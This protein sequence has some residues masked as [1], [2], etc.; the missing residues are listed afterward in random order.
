MRAPLV[1]LV[2]VLAVA[3]CGRLAESRLNPFNWFGNDEVTP[4]AATPAPL[5]ALANDPRPLVAEIA[6][7]EIDPLPDG[8]LVRATG[9]PPTQGYWDAALIPAG[10]GEAEGQPVDGVLTF[11]FVAAPPPAPARVST[12]RSRALT[13]AAFVSAQGLQGVSRIVVRAA[14]NEASTRR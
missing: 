1:A 8:A 3:G 7:L 12:P 4:V 13:A 5:S 2:A 10:A 11:Y 6:A 9:L 14:G